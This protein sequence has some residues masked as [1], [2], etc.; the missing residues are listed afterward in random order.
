MIIRPEEVPRLPSPPYFPRFPSPS[1]TPPPQTVPPKAMISLSG[2]QL[3]VR[4]FPFSI[5]SSSGRDG[6]KGVLDLDLS[7][8]LEGWR[9]NKGLQFAGVACM[10]DV[11]PSG[12]LRLTAFHPGVKVDGR[13]VPGAQ[14]TCPVKPGTLIS[15]GPIDLGFWPVG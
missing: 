14:G 5:G 10:I 15:I 11:C 8:L 4:R 7:P 9:D 12:S 6:E 2:G 1:P 13:A 3:A